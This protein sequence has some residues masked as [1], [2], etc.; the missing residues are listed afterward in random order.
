M[1]VC[2][3]IPARLASTRLARK[4]LLKET[5]MTMLEHTWRQCKQ[6]KLLDQLIVATDSEEIKAE[7]LAFGADVVMT[8][9]EASGTDRIAAAVRNAGLTHDIV[10][11]IQGDEPEM[12][13]QNIDKA[14][15][16]LQQYPDAEMSTLARPLLTRAELDAASCVKVVLAADGRALYFSRSPIPHYRDGSPDDLLNATPPISSPWLL[17]LGIYCFRRE[18]LLAVSK[19][20]P[21]MLEQMERLEQLRALQA[22]AQI[23]VGI[24]HVSAQGIDTPEDYAAFVERWKKKTTAV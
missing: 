13:P 6:A 12:D 18:F 20:P 5:G 14:V 21:S 3:I 4:M 11:N 23:Q 19:M 24:T 9:E 10:V 17:H 8:G 15:E 22:G 1:S 2:G 16:R 7:A